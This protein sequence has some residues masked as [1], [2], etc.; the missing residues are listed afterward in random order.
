MK[1]CGWWVVVF[2]LVVAGCTSRHGADPTPTSPTTSSATSVTPTGPTLSELPPEGRNLQSCS[3]GQC[4]VTVRPGDLIPVPPA[5]GGVSITIDAI[6]PAEVS[7]KLDPGN[8]GMTTFTFFA[9]PAGA[10]GLGDD[11]KF[12]VAFLDLAAGEATMQ[13][14]V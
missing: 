11:D 8:G 4:R 6:S 13:I 1:R 10:T 2:G 5:T 12:S 14:D 3:D 9:N 7:I